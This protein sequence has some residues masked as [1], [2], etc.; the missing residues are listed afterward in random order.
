MFVER[1]TSALLR[2]LKHPDP[3]KQAVYSI[4][5][6]RDNY[7]CKYGKEGWTND[8]AGIKFSELIIE[9]FLKSSKFQITQYKNYLNNLVNN[10]DENNPIYKT[11]LIEVLSRNLVKS[12]EFERDIDKGIFIKPIISELGPHLKFQDKYD[13]KEDPHLLALED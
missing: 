7:A 12:L 11:L 8:K 9:P 6:S 13:P 10:Y 1:A 2:E 4:D 3:H 5:C